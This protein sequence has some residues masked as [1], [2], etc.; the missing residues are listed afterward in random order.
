V[1]LPIWFCR[2]GAE[3]QSL[4]GFTTDL[5]DWADFHSFLLVEVECHGFREGLIELTK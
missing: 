4:F 1:N 5:T 3:V 2:Q